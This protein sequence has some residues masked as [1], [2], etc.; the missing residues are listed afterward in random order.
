MYKF[1]TKSPV[2]LSQYH[3]SFISYFIQFVT[4]S[5]PFLPI[6]LVPIETEEIQSV[7]LTMFGKGLQD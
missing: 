5:S 3:D 2:Y 6:R 1:S 7:Y 4:I